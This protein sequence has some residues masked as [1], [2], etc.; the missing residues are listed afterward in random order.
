MP[1]PGGG[2]EINMKY[3]LEEPDYKLSPYTGM[4]KKHWIE[5]C[6]LFLEGIFSHVKE[7]QDPIVI[8]HSGDK[9]SYPQPDAPEWRYAAEKFEGLARSFLIAAPLLVNEPE[10]II[11]N[12]NLKEYYKNQILA[13]VTPGTNSYL[14]NLEEIKKSAKEGEHA[15]QHTCECASLVIG[16]TISENIIWNHYTEAEKDIIAEYLSE[17]GHSRTGHH[18]WRFFNML[19]LA[20]LDRHGYQIDKGVMRDHGACILSYYAGDGWYRDGHRFDYYS[21]WAFHVYGPLWNQWYGYEQEPEMA[22]KMEE[23][24]NE[25]MDTYPNMF[26]INAHMIMWGRSSIYRSAASAP[27][28]ANLLLRNSTV[29]RG[30]ARRILSGN[31]LQFITKEEC[32]VN[33][34]PCLGYYGPYEPLI[35]SYSC[36]A[37]PFWIANSFLCLALPD[38]DEFWTAIEKNG[39]WENRDVPVEETTLDGPGMNLTNYKETGTVELRCGKVLVKK[40]DPLLSEYSRLS[41][42]SILPWEVFDFI[43][44]EAM[45]YSLLYKDKGSTQ[46]PNIL[47]YAGEKNGVLY[48]KEYF[49]FEATFQDKASID[50]ADFPV[51]NGLIR[52][53]KARIPD[54]PYILYLGHYGLPVMDT[55]NI[56]IE[57]REKNGAKAIIAKT[58]DLQV[59]MVIYTGFDLLAVKENFSKNPVTDESILIYAESKRDNYYEY[60]DYVLITAILH[61]RDNTFWSDEELFPIEQITFEDKEQCG[62]YGKITIKHSN[63]IETIIDYEGIEGSLKI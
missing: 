43:G 26:D 59:A 9:V 23:Y 7:F 42:N 50:L 22:A 60:R 28:A 14:Y 52:V 25:L 17:F 34:I 20:F 31:L 27:L 19:I 63:G 15:F 32:F 51:K 13:S 18:N 33:N 2:M 39:V 40:G 36:S 58:Q 44:P 41:F 54:K 55:E 37:S 62:G 4:T 6:H 30:L 46:I 49:D 48:R 8:P 12:Y 56:S 3:C 11:A 29:D 5:I 47:L 21:P 24:S 45:Q 57:E 61:K 38:E 35:Q 10:A 16:L 53:D 1:H